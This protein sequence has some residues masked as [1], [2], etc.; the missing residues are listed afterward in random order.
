M[1]DPAEA[2]PAPIFDT[3]AEDALARHH[4]ARALLR[5]YNATA[6]T[7]TAERRKLLEDL[8]GAAG[9]GIWIEPPF[10]CDDGGNIALGAGV[11][12]NFSCVFLDGAP[13][14]LGPGTLLGPAVQVYA[15]THPIRAEDRMFARGG[16]PAYRT[17]AEPVTIGANVW[18]GGGAIILPGVSIGDGAAIGAGAV[19]TGDVPPNVFA[20]GNP[21][22]VIRQL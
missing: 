12:I 3:R 14:T 1:D 21:C 11:F 9:E 22:R 7:E 5:A 15:T 16:I 18:I 6:S 13:I 2:K 20:A 19:V 10:H 17:S 4:R 8:L